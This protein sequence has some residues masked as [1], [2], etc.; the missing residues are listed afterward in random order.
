MGDVRGGRRLA[1]ALVGILL[2]APMAVAGQDAPPLPAD[3][4][5]WPVGH[6]EID[7]RGLKAYEDVRF[8]MGRAGKSGPLG[9]GETVE[10]AAYQLM[11]LKAEQ[12][13]GRDVWVRTARTFRVGNEEPVGQAEIVMDRRTLAPIRS[14][15]QQGENVRT[16]E[17]DWVTHQ[18]RS[19]AGEAPTDV[20]LRLDW[21]ALEAGAHE[22]WMAA[23]PW[24]QDM[25]V[26]IPSVLAG[27]GGK[28]WAVPRVVGQEEVDL[29][30]G[31][32]R[33]AWVVELDWWGMGEAHTT[34]TPGGGANG[35]AGSG[36]KYWV[37]VDPSPG[38]PRV[39]RV[40]TEASP[41]VDSVIQIQ[42]HM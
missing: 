15:M 19:G 33:S 6:P 31:E 38:L 37:L 39:V 41:E 2:V 42:D 25:R 21:A 3:V 8:S 26:M 4:P 10:E 27:G 35:T 14:E 1:A 22:T 32:S 13:D 12:R 28:W 23:I 9:F 18:I 5:V 34:F 36:G 17:Y 16:V 24:K 7:G 40:R 20:E 29:G 11:S 30:D